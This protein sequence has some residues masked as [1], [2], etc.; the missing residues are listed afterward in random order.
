MSAVEQGTPASSA[1]APPIT[2]PLRCSP[3]GSHPNPNQ[4]TVLNIFNHKDYGTC[5]V[6]GPVLS[7]AL[8][9]V[10]VEA[11]GGRSVTAPGHRHAPVR[12]GQGR[13][14]G[15]QPRR[16]HCAAG[17]ALAQALAAAAGRGGDRQVRVQPAP[18]R[19]QAHRGAGGRHGVRQAAL[20][21]VR[22]RVPQD[23]QGPRVARGRQQAR[24]ARLALLRP[25]AVLD[26]AGPRGHED[27]AAQPMQMDEEGGLTAGVPREIARNACWSGSFDFKT[28]E[29]MASLGTKDG[30]GVLQQRDCSYDRT[31]REQRDAA[32]Y[33]RLCGTWLPTYL[34]PRNSEVKDPNQT[35]TNLQWRTPLRV[36]TL[37]AANLPPDRP[38]L[39]VGRMASAFPSS[40][41]LNRGQIKS[42]D[43]SFPNNP[44]Y[45]GRAT[46]TTTTTHLHLPT[47]RQAPQQAESFRL[48]S[49][50]F[51]NEQ[52]GV[53]VPQVT[54]YFWII[55]VLATTVG[56]TF[57]D[58]LNGNVGL[59]LG[60]TSGVMLVILL[61]SLAA[62]MKLDF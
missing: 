18:D 49:M 58:F 53:K 47:P 55:K 6:S 12:H 16:G 29:I 54:I 4:H 13:D 52:V 1:L 57:A 44:V 43:P 37:A 5:S 40:V 3:G 42:L 19:V 48:P 56:E 26:A 41:R 62:Q 39:L 45:S 36:L 51:F 38:V 61:A 60:G 8:H 30:V 25:R 28:V 17:Q 50:G 11:S 14:Q 35:A 33:D 9:Q 59:G 20:L 22:G 31:K 15:A 32:P 23:P 2:T 21:V 24:L 46:P 10:P 34:Q 27:L 7:V